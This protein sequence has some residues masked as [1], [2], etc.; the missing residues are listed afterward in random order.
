MVENNV[1]EYVNR[2]KSILDSSQ[3]I[4]EQNI[5]EKIVRPLVELLDWDLYFDVESEYTIQTGTTHPRID[6]V[7]LD[8]STPEV[9]IEIKSSS[10][11]LGTD[12]RKQLTSYMKLTEV[13]WGLLTNGHRFQILR[14][15]ANTQSVEEWV[16]AE[17]SLDDLSQEWEYFEVISKEMI[18]S[19][20]AQELA[21]QLDTRKQGVRKIEE[22]K[23]NLTEEI[24]QIITE[25]AGGVLQ[26]EIEKESRDFIDNLISEL[27]KEPVDDDIPHSPEEV[28]DFVGTILPGRTEE[29]R[30]ERAAVVYTAY[31]FLQKEEKATRDEIRDHLFSKYPDVFG[32]NND[33]FERHWV[34]YIIDTLSR[35]PRIEQPARGIVQIW[36][37]VP[38][39]LSQEI[40][41]DEIDEWITELDM[42]TSG[43]GKS[44]KR[45]HSMIQRAHDHIQANG[46][47]TKDDI[48]AVLPPY[49]AHYAD[50]E[51]F[52]TSCLR[53]A[54][55]KSETVDKPTQG[56]QYWYSTDSGVTS[57]QLDLDVSEWVLEQDVAGNGA[58]KKHR[59][60]LLQYAYNFLQNNK[61]AKRSDFEKHFEQNIPEDTG[62]YRNFGGLW[63]YLLKD[64]LKEAPNVVVDGAG[65][66]G[67][68]TYRYTG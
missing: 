34:N 20:Q 39:E 42:I 35:L 30:Q 27:E 65:D 56:H 50:F 7:L 25:K 24:T 67:P 47:A 12:D 45:Q 41:V 2:S 22:A 52:W 17:I 37:Y 19:G 55:A 6:Y 61:T 26:Q 63:S 3:Q 8:D 53:K 46:K 9:L 31:S 66:R 11:G 13:D 40:L 16:L 18:L 21:D 1:E 32:E 64:G 10:A 36:R 23:E 48:E 62:R 15:Q 38:P 33:E 59:K 49:T 57:S 5:R 14:L 51:G 29:I 28:L 4:N 60:I 54:L 68:K 43:N 58:T 44:I